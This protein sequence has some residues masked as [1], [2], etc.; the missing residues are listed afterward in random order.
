[1]GNNELR[2]QGF[3]S[4]YTD[5]LSTETRNCEA[6]LNDSKKQYSLSGLA[7][8]F[9]SLPRKYSTTTMGFGV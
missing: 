6:I 2:R 3:Y 7:C 5:S 9:Q 8:E 1:M 4:F